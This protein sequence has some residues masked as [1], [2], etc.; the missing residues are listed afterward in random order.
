MI[1]SE[2]TDMIIIEIIHKI[3]HAR[4]EEKI[5]LT[6]DFSDMRKEETLTSYLY[7]KIRADILEG[8]LK[9]GEKIPS[10]RTFSR[11][12]G[13][14]T[15]TAEN[16]YAQLAAEGYLISRPRSGHYVAPIGGTLLFPRLRAD[17][18]AAN[19]K[20]SGDGELPG[21][22]SNDTEDDKSE[23]N[24]KTPEI[25]LADGRPEPETFPFGT[26]ARIVREVLQEKRRELLTRAPGSGVAVLREEIARYLLQYQGLEA[27]PDQIII[28]AGTEYL[29]S[30]LIRL[31]GGDKVY[32]VETPGYPKTARIYETN[33]VAVKYIP[34]DRSGISMQALSKSGAD[35]VHI[36]P[37]HQFPT[38]ITMPVGRRAELLEWAETSETEDRYI[39]EDDYDS[40]FRL[41]GRPIPLLMSMDRGGKVIY[42][43]TFTK[44]LASTIRISYMVLPLSLLKRYREKLGFYSC[45]VSNFEQYTLAEFIRRGYFEKHINRMRTY[46][47]RKQKMVLDQI[48]SGRLMEMVEIIGEGAGLHFILRVR[49]NRSEQELTELAD[50]AG[51]RIF[52]MS[53]YGFMAAHSGENEQLPCMVVNYCSLSE[54]QIRTFP[55]RLYAAWNM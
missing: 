6:Y 28:G 25:N 38:G 13:V 42:L 27:T 53:H 36:S 9:T 45:T 11:N 21:R 30:L 7:R 52:G 29:Y 17:P 4:F 22:R 48:R 2:I 14:S 49:T 50:G 46:Y 15:V 54:E 34:M 33:R 55:D 12:L 19:L 1:L 40:E 39:I 41:A 44:S 18:K 10:K 5:M 37:S 20:S 32:A 8:R 23:E 3:N 31:L 47:R 26:W 35:V 43:N 16:V 51:V 24:Q